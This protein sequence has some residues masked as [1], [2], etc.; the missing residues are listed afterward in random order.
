LTASNLT[1]CL[2]LWGD[3]PDDEP[4]DLASVADKVRCL[5][6]SGR[7]RGRVIA[8]DVGRVRAFG[9]SAFVT[10]AV[11]DCLVSKLPAQIGKRLLQDERWDR[12]FFKPAR[13]LGGTRVRDCNWSC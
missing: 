4:K 10:E 1:A 2:P 12:R 8:A 11:A 7:A 6:T 13:W 9:L 5:L 3:T